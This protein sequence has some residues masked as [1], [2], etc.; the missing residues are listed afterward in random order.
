MTPD[1]EEKPQ[2]GSDLQ[3]QLSGKLPL[4]TPSLPGY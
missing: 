1:S 3:T 4:K 2:I